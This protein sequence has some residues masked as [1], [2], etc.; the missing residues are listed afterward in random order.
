[1]ETKRSCNESNGQS[2]KHREN[3]PIFVSRFI[4]EFDLSAAEFR[5]YAHLSRRQGRHKAAWPSLRTI[6]AITRL[7][8]ETVANALK[9]L[10]E[11]GLIEARIAQGKHSH[12]RVLSVRELSNSAL[13]PDSAKTKLSGLKAAQSGYRAIKVIHKG[14]N[15]GE[16]ALRAYRSAYPVG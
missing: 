6:A 8:K 14:T 7:N 2:A 4:D 5:V 3:F 12:Y 13:I 9:R 10:A 11:R 1:M 16:A 15:P